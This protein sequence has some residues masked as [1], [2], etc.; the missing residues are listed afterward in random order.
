MTI[1]AASTLAVVLAGESMA[2]GG[3]L[4][5]IIGLFLIGGLVTFV[6]GTYFY[7]KSI[8]LKKLQFYDNGISFTIRYKR[9]G[10][11]CEH[12]PW[13]KMGTFIRKDHWFLGQ[14]ISVDIGIPGE[15]LLVPGTMEGFDEVYQLVSRNLEVRM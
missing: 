10:W 2:E 3:L 1:L 9:R 8:N 11:R 15:S 14:T 5:T 7:A 13:S 4:G 6:V 12:R